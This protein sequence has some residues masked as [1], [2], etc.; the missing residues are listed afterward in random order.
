MSER[1]PKEQPLPCPFCGGPAKLSWWNG[2]HQAT[3]AAVF[4]DNCAGFDVMAPIPLWNKRAAPQP[5]N[6]NPNRSE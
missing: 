4:A 3:C 6:P 5:T 1:K 2:T